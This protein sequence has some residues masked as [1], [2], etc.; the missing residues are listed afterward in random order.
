MATKIQLRRDTAVNWST[1][2]PVLSSGEPGLETDTGRIKYGDGTTVWENLAYSGDAYKTAGVTATGRAIGVRDVSGVKSFTFQTLGH[3]FVDFIANTQVIDGNTLTISLETYPDAKY[4]VDSWNQNNNVK[5][6][7]NDIQQG[8]TVTQGGSDTITNNATSVTITF[9]ATSLNY[10]VADHIKISAWVDGTQA[11]FSDYVS[12]SGHP[13]ITDTANTNTVI[14]DLSGDTNISVYSSPTPVN[15]P[16]QLTAFPGKSYI[17][18]NEFEY[19]N[20]A[21]KIVQAVNLGSNIWELTFD[22]APRNVANSFITATSANVSYNISSSTILPIPVSELPSF[23][24]YYSDGKAYV[25]VNGTPVANIISTNYHYA[26]YQNLID[27]HGNWLIELNVPITCNT[28]DELTISFTKVDDVRVDYYIPNAQDSSSGYWNNAYQWFNWHTDLPFNVAER[29]NGVR[30][31]SIKG[32]ISIY[33]PLDKSSDWTPFNFD[34]DV[35]DNLSSYT[36]VYRWANR[37]SGSNISGS[38]YIADAVNLPLNN[39][40][41]NGGFGPNLASD[42]SGFGDFVFWDF[43]EGGIFFREAPWAFNY[44]YIAQDVKV[45]IAYKMTVF[46][47]GTNDFWC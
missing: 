31:G 33:R 19:I 45:D 23:V 36:N 7:V 11:V 1:I 3:R 39:Y 14:L 8:N 47:S 2:N 42:S 26:Q 30:T 43:Y 25:S 18:L 16:D 6:Y 28:N 10:N 46:V 22:G 32:Y 35:E 37:N 29:G 38:N 15:G 12:R 17:V 21:R 44:N 27:Y 24:D 13:V 5:I 9:G 34:F 41:R 4:I 20:D 40:I